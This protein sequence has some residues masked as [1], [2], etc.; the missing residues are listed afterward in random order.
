MIVFPNAKVNLGLRILKK[1]ED[2]YH[3]IETCFFPVPICD[4]LEVVPNEKDKIKFSGIPIQGDQNDNLVMKAINMLRA[5]FDK[6][7]NL[8]IHLHKLINMGA[9]LGGG[10]ADAAFA[11]KLINDQFELGLSEEKLMDYAARIGSDCPFFIYNQPAIGRGRGEKISPFD[12]DIK[13]NYLCLVHPKIH[14]DTATAYSKTQPTEDSLSI[15]EALNSPKE[16]WREK[17]CN[18]FEPIIYEMYPELEKIKRALYAQ[19]AW[20]ASLSG[21][22]SS[23][24]AFFKDEPRLDI[25]FQDRYH[26][27]YFKF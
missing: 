12:V 13:G 26:T 27:R 21:S 19:G 20:Y 18:D 1:R 2:G 25:S 17:L 22:G 7:P 15:T 4:I 10:S 5:D 3:E 11:L 23:L 24:Y 9:G 6:I 8:S 16:E 14:I